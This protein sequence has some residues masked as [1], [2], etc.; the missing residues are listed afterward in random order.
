MRRL[1][2]RKSVMT[3]YS[4]ESSERDAFIASLRALADFLDA[5]KAVPVP[6]YGAT[7]ELHADSTED[8]G[9]L[10]VD[11]L[12]QLL[13]AEVTDETA[14]GGHYSA[15]R[16]FGLIGYEAVSIPQTCI[17]QYDADMSYRG[18]VSPELAVYPTSL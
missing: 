8:G 18:C 9:N 13:G 15:V 3:F 6:R 11:H 4:T 17:A 14:T 5:N 16:S 10:Q 7:I 12:A 2:E 1:T